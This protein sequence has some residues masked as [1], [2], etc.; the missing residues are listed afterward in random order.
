VPILCCA[1]GS[2]VG[3]VLDA[4]KGMR[5]T[6]GIFLWMSPAGVGRIVQRGLVADGYQVSF[7]SPDHLRATHHYAAACKGLMGN[8]MLCKSMLIRMPCAQ[9]VA[10]CHCIHL[11]GHTKPKPQDP[12]CSAHASWP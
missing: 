6:Y 9:M 7:S 5:I 11:W 2:V 4:K 12:V 3:V 1:L 8:V 10:P